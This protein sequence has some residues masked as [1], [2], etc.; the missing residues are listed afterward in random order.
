MQKNLPLEIS[1]PSYSRV[2]LPLSAL[3]EGEFFNEYIKR[4]KLIPRSIGNICTLTLTNTN[5]F[6]GNILMLSEGKPDVDNAYSLKE[7]RVSLLY[8]I[9][10][11]IMM[12]GY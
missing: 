3:L 11:L 4:G 10:M 6:P 1:K 5:H 8:F 12:Q 7:G 9:N 2:I